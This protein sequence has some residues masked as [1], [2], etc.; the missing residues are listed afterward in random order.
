MDESKIAIDVDVEDADYRRILYWYHRTSLIIHGILV[1]IL[2]LIA[3]LG[4]VAWLLSKNSPTSLLVNM[5]SLIFPFAVVGAL[6][7][8]R[9]WTISKQSKIFADVNEPTRFTF[10]DSGVLA[11]APSS[12]TQ[13][14]WNKYVK[15]T[16]TKDDF[17]FFPMKKWFFPLPKRFFVSDEQIL[18][19]RHLL[20]RQMGD[21]AK[22]LNS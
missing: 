1:A 13:V 22:L 16:E 12:T 4:P 6:L 8:Y 11:V 14:V 17:I 15:V 19:F 21:K 2:L 9:F 3:L 5:L 18:T 7:F 10:D 20:E